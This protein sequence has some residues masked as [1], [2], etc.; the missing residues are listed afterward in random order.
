MHEIK[1]KLYKRG[2]SFETTIPMPILFSIDTSKKQ[3][4]VFKL[5]T[6]QNKWYIEFEEAKKWQQKTC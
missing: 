4:V 2:S 1:R 5:D 3:N 6:K